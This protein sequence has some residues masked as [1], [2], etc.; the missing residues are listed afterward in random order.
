[1]V[2][3]HY[4]ERPT[5]SSSIGGVPKEKRHFATAI[6]FGLPAAVLAAP[7]TTT[8]GQ[9]MRTNEGPGVSKD[10]PPTPG[11][12]PRQTDSQRNNSGASEH[13]P[14][15]SGDGSAPGRQGS[16]RSEAC[17]SWATPTYLVFR[18]SSRK[19]GGMLAPVKIAWL[20]HGAF[21]N[22]AIAHLNPEFRG[23][24]YLPECLRAALR[25]SPSA[26]P[27]LASPLRRFRK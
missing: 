13:T 7:P 23:G 22:P 3:P 16:R 26:V 18:N 21:L 8:P 5:I 6:L 27:T 2:G 25:G 15:R 11:N 1:V 9:Q 19:A 10:A 4:L 20:V 14:N 17:H 12:P 24:R